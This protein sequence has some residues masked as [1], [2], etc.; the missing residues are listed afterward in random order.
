MSRGTTSALVGE[1]D[2]TLA[3]AFLDDGKSLRIRNQKGDVV[4]R[5]THKGTQELFDFLFENFS[6]YKESP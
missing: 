6:D 4:L 2:G 5:L 3:A 1:R